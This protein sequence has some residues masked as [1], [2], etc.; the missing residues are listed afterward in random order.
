MLAYLAGLYRNCIVNLEIGGPGDSVMMELNSLRQQLRSENYKAAMGMSGNATMLDTMRWYLYHRPDS[1]G[2]GYAYNWQTTFRTKWRL[3]G[4][5]RDSHVTDMIQ[6]NSVPCLNEMHDVTQEG[7]EIGALGG[8]LH[9]D[10]PFASALADEAWKS[11]IRP[12]MMD[13]GQTY[14]RIMGDGSQIQSRVSDVLNT[15]IMRALARPDPE[16]PV[17]KFLADRGL[18]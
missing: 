16:P 6:I 14:D 7:S 5:F 8:G 2:A 17:N 11:W 10:R 12:S 4:G 9:D 3:M 15:A 13:M 1:M 18:V